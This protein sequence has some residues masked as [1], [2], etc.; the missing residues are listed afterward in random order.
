MLQLKD[1]DLVH[2]CTQ[3]SHMCNDAEK[4]SEIE[5]PTVVTHT[6]CCGTLQGP[7]NAGHSSEDINI[8]VLRVEILPY[9]LIIIVIDTPILVLLVFVGI[10]VLLEIGFLLIFWKIPL[11][12]ACGHFNMLYFIVLVFSGC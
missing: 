4:T 10:V 11:H 8:E 3:N 5:I 12:S 7:I 9:V 1:P 2:M 6:G